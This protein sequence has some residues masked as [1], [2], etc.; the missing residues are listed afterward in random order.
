MALRIASG[1]IAHHP[2]AASH[3]ASSPFFCVFRAQDSTRHF[4]MGLTSV[5]L[6]LDLRPLVPLPPIRKHL[7]IDGLAHYPDSPSS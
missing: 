2:P 3:P 6:P 4:T 7:P 1:S 5:Y